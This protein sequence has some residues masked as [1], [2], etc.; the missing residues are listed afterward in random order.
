MSA[1][2]RWFAHTGIPVAGYDRTPTP[3]TAELQSAGMFISYH[4]QDPATIPSLF[5]QDPAKTLVIYTPAIPPDSALMHFFAASGYTML[6]RSQ[7]LGLL[8]ADMP[9]IAVAGTHGKTTTSAMVAHIMRHAAKPVLAF[10]GGITT[11]YKSNL[12]LPEPGTAL[13]DTIA[14]VEADEYDRSFLQLRPQTA[15]ITS[16]DPDHL[17]IYGTPEHMLDS[18]RAFSG[19]IQEGGL[20]I[21]QHSLENALGEAPHLKTL[22]YGIDAGQAQAKSLF[23]YPD[24][25]TGEPAGFSFTIIHPEFVLEALSLSMPGKHNVENALAAACACF[26][27]GLTPAQ[28]FAGLESFTGVQRRFERHYTGHGPVLYDDYAHHPTEISAL[29]NALR[30][31]YPARHITAIF[32]PHL[33]SRTRDFASGFSQA[34]SFADRIILLPIYPARELPIEGVSSNMLSDGLTSS[35]VLFSTL[36]DL[37]TL[38]PTLPLDIVTTVG[39]GDIGAQVPA[40]ARLLASI[41]RSLIH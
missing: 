9:S 26:K 3:L 13:A 36:D 11:N 12:L 24:P 14:V 16:L 23:P 31:L 39:A 21:V 41:P 17:D 33:F 38:L 35:E 19:C 1:L 34:L 25:D 22:S 5:R 8:T 20:R 18:Y 2:A 7:V 37:E 4:N 6:K 40:I 30:T 27:A 15:I 32:Q 10:V 29:L 28:I